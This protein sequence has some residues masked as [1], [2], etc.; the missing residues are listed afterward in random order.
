MFSSQVSRISVPLLFFRCLLKGDFITETFSEHLTQKSNF[1][2]IP[3]WASFALFL[4]MTLV[5][6]SMALSPLY[7]IF[8]AF[9][10]PPPSLDL[11]A[12]QEQKLYLAGSVLILHHLEHVHAHGVYSIKRC[13][14]EGG[15]WKRENGVSWWTWSI[16]VAEWLDGGDS[17]STELEKEEEKDSS[18]GGCASVGPYRV[19][20]IAFPE[21][22]KM[23]GGLG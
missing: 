14:M 11:Q 6:T 8:C 13:W 22:E 12:S 10:P 3:I 1:P 4:L 5:T 17:L 16:C 18:L 9:F 7:I 20:G 15:I 19:E 23:E 2:S 21:W